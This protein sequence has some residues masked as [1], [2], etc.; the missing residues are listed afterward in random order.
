MN[1]IISDLNFEKGDGLLPAIIQDSLTSQVL[2]LG[3][4]NEESLKITVETGQVTFFS[5]SKNKL[6]TKGETSGNYFKMVSAEM[7]CDRD[8]MLIKVIPEGPACH[9]G[10]VSCFSDK[11][12]GFLYKLEQVIAHRKISGDSNSYVSGLFAKGLNKIAQ[13]VGE[14]AVETVIAA[15][16]ETDE[17]FINE[18]SDLMFHFLILLQQKGRKLADIEEILVNRHR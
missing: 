9:T 3:Y 10:S 4:V 13:K 16:N 12:M 1:L 15:I 6:W 5:R 18:A 8:S 14:E 17:N 2:M 11:Q 7:D